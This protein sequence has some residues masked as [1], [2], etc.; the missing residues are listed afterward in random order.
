MAYIIPLGLT[1]NNNGFYPYSTYVPQYG[2]PQYVTQTLTRVQYPPTQVIQGPY[3]TI[4]GC[5]LPSTHSSNNH[6]CSRCGII[7]HE[8][9]YR[10][11]CQVP[12]CRVNIL[13]IHQANP[14]TAPTPAIHIEEITSEEAEKDARLKEKEL[15]LQEQEAR[16]RE[17][18]SKLNAEEEAKLKAEESARLKEEMEEVARLEKEEEADRL[19]EA[20]EEL[21][22][23][24]EERRRLQICKVHICN[25]RLEHQTSHHPCTY[26]FCRAKNGHSESECAWKV[27]DHMVGRPA[28]Y[29][30]RA[31]ACTD[32]MNHSFANHFCNFCNREGGNRQCIRCANAR[33]IDMEN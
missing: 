31:I 6:C 33:R 32:R 23:L 19:K 26:A 28:D 14:T 16:L 29:I 4:T 10:P 25:K 22:R 13:H 7:G 2:P 5:V 1:V 12:L 11:L 3:C 18:E 9:P 20:E 24:K 21:A 15:R 30:C 8:C 27:F 17:R